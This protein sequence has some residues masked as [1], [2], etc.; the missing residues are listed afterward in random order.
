MFIDR[1]LRLNI[2]LEE[3]N[4][5]E[6]GMFLVQVE[7]ECNV[8]SKVARI[9]L[10]NIKRMYSRPELFDSVFGDENDEGPDDGSSEPVAN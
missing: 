6:L 5:V 2:V 9:I 8:K 1:S 4:A 7:K 3:E 10:E